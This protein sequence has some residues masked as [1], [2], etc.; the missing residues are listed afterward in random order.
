[1]G[2]AGCMKNSM[3]IAIGMLAGMM[4][5]GCAQGVEKKLVYFGHDLKNP[6][7]LAEVMDE[8]QGIP[9]DGL[10]IHS[11]WCY[12]FYI[13]GMGSPDP[14]CEI[15][16]KMK[17]GRFTDNF[18]YMTG[19]KKVDWFDDELWAEDGEILK[20]IRALAKIGAAG[21]CKGIL[22]DPEFVYWGQGD[23]TWKVAQQAQYGKKTF[24]EFED[25]VRRRGVAVI[26]AIEEHMPNTAFLT[27]FWGSM[28]RF[29]DAAKIH[30]P[31][32]YREVAK[33][34]YYGLLNAFMCGFSLRVAIAAPAQSGLDGCS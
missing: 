3:L 4:T 25:M 14:T 30:D 21:R 7:Q 23:N 34:D 12:P 9:F 27:L 32:L 20:N 29:K 18:M 1:M 19:G 11:N 26:D 24:A 13:K 5:A 2:K 8:L 16:R 6:G 28:G 22:F 10:A 31:K 15:M 17:W 33:E